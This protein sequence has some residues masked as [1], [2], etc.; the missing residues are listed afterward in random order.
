ML[1]YGRDLISLVTFAAENLSPEGVQALI[2]QRTLLQQNCLY[3]TV[4]F[5][6]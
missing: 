3:K 6:V 1:L 5:S 2:A 4:C